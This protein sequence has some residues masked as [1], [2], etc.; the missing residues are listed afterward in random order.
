MTRDQALSI[1]VESLADANTGQQMAALV[2]LCDDMEHIG[3]MRGYSTGSNHTNKCLDA[4]F[5]AM[6]KT[7]LLVPHGT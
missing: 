1:Y 2:K 7:S 5:G 4:V 6:G 3:F